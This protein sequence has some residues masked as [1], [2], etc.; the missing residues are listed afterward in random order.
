MSAVLEQP[1]EAAAPAS[2][3]LRSEVRRFR[4]RRFIQ[5]L[6]G[7]SVL[8]WLGALA[9]GL[10]TF[11]V[12]DEADY[13]AAR[14]EIDNIVA[15]Q[16]IFYEQCLDDPA[17]PDDVPVEMYCGPPLT[18]DDLDVENF[19]DVRPFSF[20]DTAQN[21][22]LAFAAAG[23][24]LCFLVGATWIGAE[25]ST[26][27]IVA[28]LFWEPRRGRLMATKFGVLAA[29]CAVIGAAT[30]LAWLAM[31]GILSVAAGDGAAVPPGFWGDLLATQ[32]RAVL[33]AV[34]I[35]LLGFGLTN[36]VHNTGAALGIGFVYFAVLET[37]IRVIRPAW[38]PWL[39]T[40]NAGGL[41]QQGG[42]QLFIWD[43][44]QVSRDGSFVPTEYLLGN[45]QSGVFLVAVTAVIAAVGFVLFAR[46]DV[47]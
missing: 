34:L 9:I 25:W 39:L 1:T 13:A 18:A 4:S 19:L 23:A 21:G 42:L 47:H 36:L 29:A 45:V 5:V 20:V 27:S 38:Q 43:S 12:P 33:L 46:R 17:R 22:A 35:G 24:V 41:V 37:A 16:Q 6:L 7:L 26:R 15:E 14:A 28:L 2:G 40:N 44:E 30:Q 3:L 11:G 31:S 10:L 32:G 8:G